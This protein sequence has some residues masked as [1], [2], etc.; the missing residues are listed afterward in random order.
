MV[1]AFLAYRYGS[2]QINVVTNTMGFQSFI[3]Q[4][5]T[6]GCDEFKIF[7]LDCLFRLKQNFPYS[8]SREIL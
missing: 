4:N 6:K 3:L 7:A 2:I 1:R 5:D 8:G